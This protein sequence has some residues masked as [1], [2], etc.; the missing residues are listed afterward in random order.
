MGKYLEVKSIQKRLHLDS[1]KK[2]TQL[3]TGNKGRR[4]KLH[5]AKPQKASPKFGP[6]QW[7]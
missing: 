1:K 5:K 2:A 3:W 4:H 7:R 6:E